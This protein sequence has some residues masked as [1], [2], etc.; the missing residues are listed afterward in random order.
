MK[1]RNTIVN[2]LLIEAVI[3]FGVAAFLVWL[4]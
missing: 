2:D 1:P 3:V 4:L